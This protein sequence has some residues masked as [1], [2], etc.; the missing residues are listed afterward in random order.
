MGR[1]RKG[2][3]V[4]VTRGREGISS[5]RGFDAGLSSHARYELGMR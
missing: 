5:C 4:W 1:T 3:G 2:N